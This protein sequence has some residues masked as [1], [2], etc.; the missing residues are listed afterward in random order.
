M[1]GFHEIKRDEKEM[2]SIA[3]LVEYIDTNKNS[4][5]GK[6]SIPSLKVVSN[7]KL[8]F[9]DLLVCIGPLVDT[10]PK[11]SLSLKSILIDHKLYTRL[12]DYTY[13]Q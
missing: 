11:E 1:D 2:I 7:E 6:R 8:T 9:A 3:D 5:D 13:R 10:V 4:E 12:I